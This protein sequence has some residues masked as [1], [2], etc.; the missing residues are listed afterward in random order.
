MNNLKSFAI[1]QEKFYSRLAVECRERNEL[2]GLYSRKAGTKDDVDDARDILTAL[3]EGERVNLLSCLLDGSYGK[4]TAA[5]IWRSIASPRA[6]HIALISQLMC[7]H[8][9]QAN[10][11]QIVRAWKSLTPA[12]KQGLED[13]IRAVILGVHADHEA[14]LAA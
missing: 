9:T 2:H 3:A 6:N 12:Q 5:A 14:E 4:H 13:T 11:S 8:D 1:A 7:L 10:Q